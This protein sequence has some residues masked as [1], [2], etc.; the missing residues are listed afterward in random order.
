[1]VSGIFFEVNMAVGSS[2]AEVHRIC[3][4]R[5]LLF[6][7]SKAKSQRNYLLLINTMYQGKPWAA[8]I[9]TAC[10]IIERDSNTRETSYVCLCK[11]SSA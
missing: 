9:V 6:A 5:T 11:V 10:V 8:E 3:R 1:V 2:S 7:S 4:V